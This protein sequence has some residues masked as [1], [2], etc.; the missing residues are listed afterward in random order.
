MGLSHSYQLGSQMAWTT[1][2]ATIASKNPV[3]KRKSLPTPPWEPVQHATARVLWSRDNFPGRT[4]S[5]PQAVA[6]SCWPLLLQARPVFQLWLPYPSLSPAWV[7]K[8]DLIS[9]CFNPLLSGQGTDA[10][11][12]PTLRG[13]TKTQ[14]EPQEICEQRKERE[15]SPCNLK[16][17]RLNTHSQLDKPCIC[18]IPE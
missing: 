4:H 17:S 2:T 7:S 18:G 12:W 10:W 9:H 6:M 3:C 5:T 13:G 1:N 8:K 16:S 15:I 14:A 11:G